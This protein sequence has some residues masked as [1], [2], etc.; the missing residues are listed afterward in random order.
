PEQA[1]LWGLGRVLANE[2]P[3]L[4]CRL[5]DVDRAVDGI[6]DALIRELTGA[7]V[8]EEVILTAHGRLVP[9]MLTATQAAARND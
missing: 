2:H 6:P 3:E 1:T 8:E 7:A 4:A 5:I 9:R